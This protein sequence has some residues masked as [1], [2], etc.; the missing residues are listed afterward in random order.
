MERTQKKKHAF[1]YK[2]NLKLICKT[3]EQL[4]KQMPTV[5]TFNDD[6]H[7][8]FRL[9]KC[10]KTVFKN[11]KLVHSQ[12]LMTDINREILEQGKA[13]KYLWTGES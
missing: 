7:M 4:K 10:T 11:G 9:D 5:R 12:N 6:I 2:Y 8:E 3:E 13:C 1:C